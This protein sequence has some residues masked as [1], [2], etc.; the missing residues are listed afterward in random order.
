MAAAFVALDHPPTR[1]ALLALASASDMLDGWLARRSGRTS[2]LGALLDPIADKVFV[3]VALS[4]F[5]ARGDLGLAGFLIVLSRDIATAVGFFVAWR[6]PELRPTSFRARWPGKL[7]T[8][9]QILVLVSLIIAPGML[10]LLLPAI[11]AASVAA[12][13]DY[14]YALHRSRVRS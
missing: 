8:V 6:H 11:A 12:I 1:L 13:I 4:V 5:L 10:T 9:L 7:V 14:T 3:L 2:T